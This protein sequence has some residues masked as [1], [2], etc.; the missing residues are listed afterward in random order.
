MARSYQETGKTTESIAAYKKAV[1]VDPNYWMAYF[2]LGSIYLTQREYEKAA[3]QFEK[4]SSLNK[5]HWK[6]FYN[7]GIA[8]QALETQEDYIDAYHAYSTFLK[9]TKGTKNKKIKGMQ[10]QAQQIVNQLRD[11]FEAEAIDYEQ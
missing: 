11:Y 8:R 3:E 5:K 4:S 9:L 7:L 10:K 2:Q 1:K 6:S